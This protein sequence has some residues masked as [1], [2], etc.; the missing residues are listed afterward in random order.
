MEARRRQVLEGI[1]EF[2][3]ERLAV[4]DEFLG[5]V[6]TDFITPH[7]FREKSNALE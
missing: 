2:V 1:E 4:E 5:A 7:S 6:G 3:G